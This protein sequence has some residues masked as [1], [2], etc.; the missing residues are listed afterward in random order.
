M[1]EGELIVFV[2]PVIVVFVSGKWVS[3]CRCRNAFIHSRIPVLRL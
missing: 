3:P 1:G 2:Q